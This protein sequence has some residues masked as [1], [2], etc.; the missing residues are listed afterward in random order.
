MNLPG[1]EFLVDDR[2]RKKAVLIDLKK[3]RGLWEDFYDAYLAHRRRDEP[4][5]PLTAIKRRLQRKGKHKARG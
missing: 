2:G 4:R 5:E 1:V 3:Q